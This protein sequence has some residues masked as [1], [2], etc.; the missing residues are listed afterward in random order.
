M[1]LKV[2]F[3]KTTMALRVLSLYLEK[4]KNKNNKN[5]DMLSCCWLAVFAN[6]LKHT[7]VYHDNMLLANR[8]ILKNL[9]WS[10][11]FTTRLVGLKGV[12]FN[13]E[14]SDMFFFKVCG[15][16]SRLCH[17]SVIKESSF[18]FTKSVSHADCLQK[19]TSFQTNDFMYIHTRYNSSLLVRRKTFRLMW[20]LAIHLL[21]LPTDPCS[22]CALRVYPASGTLAGPQSGTGVF[23]RHCNCW[24]L[25]HQ[26]I[27][28]RSEEMT[29]KNLF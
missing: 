21:S 19:V 12:I 15:D 17:K 13:M 29:I 28:D 24:V 22:T 3:K 23:R 14:M 16:C 4:I 20:C 9:Y 7:K 8:P 1:N 25:K 11:F 6:V 2:W 5:S 27:D 18:I 10:L 26:Q